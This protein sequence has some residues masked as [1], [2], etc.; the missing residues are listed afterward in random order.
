VT[1]LIG[2]NDIGFSASPRIASTPRRMGRP[3]ATRRG[4][5]AREAEEL[6]AMVAEHAAANGATLVDWY[7]A[8]IGHDACKL[9]V[10]RWVEPLVPVS[11]AAPVHPNLIGMQAA[12][13]LVA[14][15]AR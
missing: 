1:L 11:P 12:S 10:I 3:A 15:A 4:L 14:A 2:G 8:S 5:A 13:K 7:G 6:N 9:A